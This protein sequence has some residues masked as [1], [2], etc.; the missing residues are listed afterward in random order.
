MGYCFLETGSAEVVS[1]APNPWRQPPENLPGINTGVGAKVLL[2]LAEI[3]RDWPRGKTVSLSDKERHLRFILAVA[4][5]PE[6]DVATRP[7]DW[8]LH[9]KSVNALYVSKMLDDIIGMHE[10]TSLRSSLLNRDLNHR[11]SGQSDNWKDA[12]R[13]C[14][15]LLFART[16][17][18]DGRS[19]DSSYYREE[20]EALLT[21][22]HSNDNNRRGAWWPKLKELKD[23]R[24]P[25]LRDWD[26]Q[27]GPEKVDWP[28]SPTPEYKKFREEDDLW[29]EERELWE[30]FRSFSLQDN[31]GAQEVAFQFHHVQSW[32]DRVVPSHDELDGTVQRFL[33]GASLMLELVA[34][35][36]RQRIAHKV[37]IGSITVDGGGRVVFQCPEDRLK[38]MKE[39]LWEVP[40]QFLQVNKT[41]AKNNV[42]FEAMIED[43]AK[44]CKNLGKNLEKPGP[45]PGTLG[46]AEEMGEAELRAFCQ[47]H[48][49]KIESED[50]EEDEPKSKAEILDALDD[51]GLLDDAEKG[52]YERW[53]RQIRAELPPISI[54]ELAQAPDPPNS[55]EEVILLLESFPSPKVVKGAEEPEDGCW[56]CGTADF[57]EDCEDEDEEAR[58]T[59][60]KRKGHKIDSLMGL[61]GKKSPSKNIC[62]FHRLLYFLGHD[63]RL[64]DSTLRPPKRS[65]NPKGMMFRLISFLTG[66]GK[67]PRKEDGGGRMTTAIARIDG[68]S[69]GIIFRDDC[70]G[71]DVPPDVLRDRK[72]RRSFR[73]NY[74]WWHSIQQSVDKFGTGDRIAAWVTAGDDVILAQYDRIEESC[75]ERE[76]KLLEKTLHSLAEEIEQGDSLDG[77]MFLSF[78]AGVALKRPSPEPGSTDRILAQ[79]RRAEELEEQAKNRWKIVAEEKW[80]NMLTMEDGKRKKP[81]LDKGERGEWISG[82]KSVMAVDSG[83]IATPKAKSKNPES[84]E[85][86][87]ENWTKGGERLIRKIC[88]DHGLDQTNYPEIYKA[89]KR[90]YIEE[91]NG[92]KRLVVLAP[93]KTG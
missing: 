28:G 86:N 34:S 13:Q 9:G 27:G 64:K 30:R 70:R 68:N 77:D 45:I 4:G 66:R 31:L 15:L 38:E 56:F 33:R 59:K 8:P 47:E 80:K 83:D 52:D 91:E 11:N 82:T 61:E 32:I 44:A 85:E 74:H 49:F 60:R 92:S 29:Q 37:G 71:D 62:P 17:Q 14:L 41:L 24:K 81:N 53:F 7:L 3:I 50:E 10:G 51:A 20:E 2:G 26:E 16:R 88:R 18:L 35:E 93:K 84:E 79:L 73:F 21:H 40:E 48:E 69:L 67:G 87:F 54:L 65:N 55:V 89:L 39:Q 42:R 72:R 12:H 90:H 63:Q 78:G 76:E 23:Y 75:Q 57:F 36:A 19:L 43:W 1:S 46:N 5:Y 58:K 25:L 22:L 6:I